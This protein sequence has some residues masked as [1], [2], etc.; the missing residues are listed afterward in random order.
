[1]DKCPIRLEVLVHFHFS[2]CQC[3]H[4][5]N[6]SNNNY[7]HKTKLDNRHSCNPTTKQ[8]CDYYKQEKGK[9]ITTNNLKKT[10]LNELFNNGYIDEEDSVLDKRQK[11]YYPLVE[12]PDENEEGRQEQEKIRNCST[13]DGV[14][15]FTQY[16]KLILPKNCTNI[17]RNWLKSET[18]DLMKYP[19]KVE[20]FALLDEHDNELCI[21]RFEKE[22]E[23]TMRLS[24]YFSN[25]KN[26]S[27][28]QKI[29]RDIKYLGIIEVEQYEKLS[30]Q[31][32]VVQFSISTRDL[33]TVTDNSRG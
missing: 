21:C 25:S 1:M 18:F 14:D 33:I 7:H 32:E 30:T 5:S 27:N 8:L 3:N 15:N 11:I 19:L 28:L 29:F 24:G 4:N 23:K 22:Y 20:K 17:P 10:Y 12:F 6:N 9:I 16:S 13:F 31:D 2:S 26:D